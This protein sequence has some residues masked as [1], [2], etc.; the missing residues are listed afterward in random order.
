MKQPDKNLFEIGHI[1]SNSRGISSEYW[2]TELSPILRQLPLI[3]LCIPGTIKS[4][5]YSTEKIRYNKV[6]TQ[7]SSITSQLFNGIR[8]LNIDVIPNIKKHTKWMCTSNI[9]LQVIL[10][11]INLFAIT[12]LDEVIF[13]ELN[14]INLECINYTIDM[15][16]HILFTKDN[17]DDFWIKQCSINS[18]CKTRKNVILLNNNF[19][20]KSERVLKTCLKYINTNSPEKLNYFLNLAEPSI[21]STFK[22]PKYTIKVNWTTLE[23]NCNLFEKLFAD[24]NK[25]RNAISLSHEYIIQYVNNHNTNIENLNKIFTLCVEFECYIDLLYLCIQIMDKR[26]F[27]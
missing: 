2:M 5:N 17:I 6:N 19:S 22:I 25:Y 7:H 3:Y 10:R 20:S 16:K 13:L 8:Y 15:L 11:Q 26:F 23:N 14:T 4:H 9:S 27:Q 12:H 24:E 1:L 21:C 18:I